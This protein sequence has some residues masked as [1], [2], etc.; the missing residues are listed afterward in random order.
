MNPA[1]Q[2]WIE[3]AEESLLIQ[4]ESSRRT[5]F[6]L[7]ARSKYT[8]QARHRRRRGQAKSFHGAH[9]RCRRKRGG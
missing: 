5:P 9:R 2:R 7:P 8:T 4:E 3:A 1:Q 6:E